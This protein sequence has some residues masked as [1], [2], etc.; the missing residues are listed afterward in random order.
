MRRLEVFEPHFSEKDINMGLGITLAENGLVPDFP[1]KLA[2]RGLIRQ[3]L[4]DIEPQDEHD[5]NLVFTEQLAKASIMEYTDAA[6]DQ[7]YEVPAGFKLALGKQ[8]KYSS[9]YYDNGAANLD[10]AEEDMLSLYGGRS[11]TKG[12]PKYLDLGCG[13]GSFLYGQQNAFPT[14]RFMAYQ[15]LKTNV[16]ILHGKQIA[17]GSKM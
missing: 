6:N 3:R 7:H 13:W 16:S 11:T 8:P 2:I 12:W 1:I 5:P 9:C 4:Q 14:H 10:Q 17:E 15:I